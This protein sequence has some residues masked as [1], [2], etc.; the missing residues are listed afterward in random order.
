MLIANKFVL[1]LF[2]FL[3]VL[4]QTY[5]VEAADQFKNESWPYLSEKNA[6]LQRN[7]IYAPIV[8]ALRQLYKQSAIDPRQVC[9]IA[10]VSK[11][12]QEPFI[13]WWQGCER[14]SKIT[15]TPKS[16]FAAL[17]RESEAYTRPLLNAI[18]KHATQSDLPFLI[19]VEDIRE[20]NYWAM[21]NSYQI[22][23]Q[24]IH[25]NM[26]ENTFAL[27]L[28]AIEGDNTMSPYARRRLYDVIGDT[29]D[30]IALP[31]LVKY[32][33]GYMGELEIPDDRIVKAIHNIDPNQR[34]IK[35][36]FDYCE[37][38]TRNDYVPAETKRARILKKK[39]DSFVSSK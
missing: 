31:T 36:Y 5:H 18:S 22:V 38:F 9:K 39:L 35:Q 2:V 11:P 37:R 26:N 13:T 23:P 33:F 6:S 32:A 8:S 19:F 30:P 16:D 27:L 4:V 20:L 29:H 1:F 34:I 24:V 28:L 25:K 21:G 12:L 15:V 7:S 3:S 14:D 10:K 17:D